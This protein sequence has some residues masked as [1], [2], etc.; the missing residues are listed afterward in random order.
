MRALR[1]AARSR[2]ATALNPYIGYDKAAEIVKEAAASGRSL[3]EVAREAGVE[4][5]TCSTRRSTTA[6][7]PARTTEASPPVASPGSEQL[8]FGFIFELGGTSGSSVIREHTRGETV[9]RIVA[10]LV[11]TSLALL[12]ALAT[13]VGTAAAAGQANGT[14]VKDVG[15]NYKHG[16]KLAISTQESEQVSGQPPQ[17]NAKVGSVRTWL[18]LDDF[19]NRIYLKNYT[20]RGVGNHIEVWVANNL[21]FPDHKGKP[22]CRNTLGLTTVTDAQIKGFISEFDTNIWPKEAEAFSVAPARDG[23]KAI[24]PTLIPNLPS[25]EYKGDGDKTVILIDNVRDDNY[26]EPSHN[27]NDV[28]R[29]LLLR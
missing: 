14:G 22:D 3:R 26:Y 13:G 27:G 15:S 21:A 8:F 7:W 28:H 18:G 11:V 23:H 1:G 9:R 17:G 12:V 16:K 6:A 19:N 5:A 4:E 10:G 25:S 29:G 2:A 20:L 24:L